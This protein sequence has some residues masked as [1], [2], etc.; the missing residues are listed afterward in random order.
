MR[1]NGAN[2][3]K[4]RGENT[5]RYKIKIEFLALKLETAQ[6]LLRPYI[7]RGLEEDRLTG[8]PAPSADIRS[9][10]LRGEKW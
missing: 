4:I 9:I 10:M 6:I 3:A 7:G 2:I 5:W 8:T 1:L